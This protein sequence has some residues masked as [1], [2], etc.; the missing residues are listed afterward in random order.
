MRWL[1]VVL[2]SVL[3]VSDIAG[4][5]PG[6]GPGLSL[7]NALLYLIALALFFRLA[8]GGQ[9]RMRLPVIHAC[10]AI[11]IG[12]ALLTWIAAALVIHYHGYD[13]TQ[14]AIALKSQ[15]IDSALF[16][17]TVFYGVQEESDFRVVMK[18]LALALCVSSV[19]TLTDVVGLTSLGTRIG[20]TGAEADRVFGAFGNAN[21]TGALIVCLAPAVV[22]VAMSSRGVWRLLW[23]AGAAASLAVLVL[24][25]SRGAFLGL[26]IGYLGAVYVCRR[27]L[28]PSRVA[29]WVLIGSTVLVLAVGLVSLLQPRVAGVVTERIFGGSTTIDMG[30][31]SSGRTAI[32]ERAIQE[33]MSTPITL[34][35]GF[36]WDVYSAMPFVYVTHN[37]YLD[38]W[39][40][41]GLLG[42]AVFVILLGYS[43]LTARRAADVATEPLRGYMIA[44]TFGMLAL[45]VAMFFA[46]I[47]TTRPYLWIYVGLSMRAAVLVFDTTEQRSV[48]RKL[49][50]DAQ[51]GAPTS[52]R[53]A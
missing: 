26:I 7:K 37:Q 40:N 49:A 12:Y 9:L 41:L 16:C 11:W 14:S 10:F 2:I 39:F 42:V 22:A 23:Y 17:F 35:T 44:F 45:A 34:L 29:A 4:R 38:Q 19:A 6:L 20:T 32:W 48:A 27:F 33:M 31:V 43:I 46:N 5:N 47:Y 25:V 18:A 36:G 24:T 53:Q 8:L 28:S 15:L 51:G 21:E 13:A 1:F 30:E 50:G 52:W 3:T